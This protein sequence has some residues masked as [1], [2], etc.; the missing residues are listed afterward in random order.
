MF[1]GSKLN[2]V[3]KLNH[4]LRTMATK[5]PIVG[6][7]EIMVSRSMPFCAV[8]TFAI[9]HEEKTR[10]HSPNPSHFSHISVIWVIVELFL[11]VVSTKITPIWNCE[12]TSIYRSQSRMEHP[13][14]RSRR[15]SDGL[16]IVLTQTRWVISTN[17]QNWKLCT[18]NLE[19][20]SRCSVSFLRYFSFRVFPI[21]Y[22]HKSVTNNWKHLWTRL[23]ANACHCLAATL[24]GWLLAWS[25][26]E[27]IGVISMT[28][29]SIHLCY[30]TCV[31]DLFVQPALRRAR[32][33]LGVHQVPLRGRE[34]GGRGA[35][36][37]FL[38]LSHRKA[39]VRRT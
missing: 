35:R 7:E 30:N 26:F 13:M 2:L 33:V 20:I 32:R 29:L 9:N 25:N 27:I 14:R 28:K 1:F 19:V 8:S 6:P 38:W 24:P 39:P 23:K 31:L 17:T 37:H 15:A 3:T 10:S 36:N 4:P 16:W 34:E 18:P 11:H 5:Y 21:H 12:I 22:R